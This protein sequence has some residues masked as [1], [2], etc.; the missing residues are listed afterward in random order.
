MADTSN[1]AALARL[2]AAEE[3]YDLDYGGA[4]DSDEDPDFGAKPKPKRAAG[5]GGRRGRKPKAAAA[6]AVSTAPEATAAPSSLAGAEGAAGAPAAL[7]V[8]AAQAQSPPPPQQQE[9]PTA[10][11]EGSAGDGGD[12][13][14]RKRKDVGQQR[15]AARTWTDEE[16]RLFQEAL[17]LHGRDWRAC[18]AHVGTRDHKA[19]ASHTQARRR[20]R[21]STLPGPRGSSDASVR[22]LARA[23]PRARPARSGLPPD[24][25]AATPLHAPRRLQKYLIKLLLRGEEVPG[26]M[27]G[28][29]LGYTLSGK[30]LDPD[31]AAARA[32]GLRPDVFQQIVSQG[33]LRTGEHVTSLTM[34]GGAPAAKRQKRG[35]G[36]GSRGGHD[37]SL[38]DSG[39]E[40]EIGQRAQLGATT[41]ALDLTVPRQFVG[42]PGSGGPQAQP[43]AVTVDRG[44]LL[45]MD[46]HAHL[47]KC[48]VIGLLGGRFDPAQRSLDVVAA[49]P[50]RCSAGAESGTSVELDPESQVEAV[51]LM[52]GEGLQPVG[53]YHSHPVFDPSPSIKDNENQRN[54][55]ARRNL[56]LCSG[57]CF[58][59]A[60]EAC[61]RAQGRRQ[62]RR[63]GRGWAP[64][65]RANRSAARPPQALCACP[66]SGLEPWVGAIV[67]PYDTELR[68]TASKI[69]FW[70]VKQHAGQLLP[71][72]VRYTPAGSGA[73]PPAPVDA[74]LARAAA[75]TADDA[76]RVDLS[77]E[78]RPFSAW[79]AG[80]EP[81]GPPL[82]H[83]A[84]LRGALRAHL[85]RGGGGAAAFLARL[86]ALLERA[87][88]VRLP[89]P[90]EAAEEEGE[91]A[92]AEPAAQG[93]AHEQQQEQGQQGQQQ[94]GG[95]NDARA[96]NGVAAAAVAAQARPAV[97]A[98][99]AGAADPPTA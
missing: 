10:R 43:F 60:A 95:Q 2:L 82:S 99:D 66:A 23:A 28:S 49:Y 30:P 79:T 78:W 20:R 12:G 1:D 73:P 53:W 34:T 45:V 98:D 25:G 70:V 48:E 83:L 8:A 92:A 16:E 80:G 96:A 57:G 63:A 86:Q 44:A 90:E 91:A 72:A 89:A 55:Q 26:K 9:Q 40:Y 46:A 65:R 42:V 69:Q 35:G 11:A 67:G 37:S 14:R 3:G 52:E 32:Y 51:S 19:I 58:Q 88:G 81:V 6:Q 7:M 47:S 77:E 93:S 27:K 85:P 41:E 59:R 22:R 5:G 18:A 76:G 17:A 61:R 4:D 15:A 84:K 38:S 74:A 97:K 29:G 71:Y 94:P 31:S 21:R 36:G 50:C 62:G 33:L 54:Y 87:W 24:P 64:G 13:G 56:L 68:G 75:A 39:E